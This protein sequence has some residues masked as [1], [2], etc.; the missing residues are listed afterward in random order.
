MDRVVRE[1]FSEEVIIE[2]TQIRRSKLCEDQWE[3]HWG[4]RA[5]QMQRSFGRNRVKTMS[6]VCLR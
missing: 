4:Q 3:M 1:G 2:Q 6:E 5:Q